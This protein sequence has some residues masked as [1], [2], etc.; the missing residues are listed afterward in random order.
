MT[1]LTH[2][3]SNIDY[4]R[5]D[6]KILGLDVSVDDVRPVAESDTLDHLIREES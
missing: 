6:E 5:V 4:L 3:D 1:R 2:I